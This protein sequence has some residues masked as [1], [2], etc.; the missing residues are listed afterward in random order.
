VLI[1]RDEARCITR[2]IASLKGVVDK[3]VVLDTGSRDATPALAAAAGAQVHHLPWPDDF[4]A[5]RNHALDLA[6]AAWNLIVDADEWL[7][8]GAEALR[9][10]CAAAP[11]QALRRKRGRFNRHRTAQPRMDQ[12]PAARRRAL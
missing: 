11:W 5:A 9:E 3:V 4:S 2:C 8:S 12:P 10:F 1:A 7:E 6:G